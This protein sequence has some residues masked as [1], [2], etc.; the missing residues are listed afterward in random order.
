MC[1]FRWNGYATNFRVGGK[2]SGTNA[3]QLDEVTHLALIGVNESNADDSCDLR[4]WVTST[5]LPHEQD[6]QNQPKPAVSSNSIASTAAGVRE[7]DLDDDARCT[8]VCAVCGLLGE[9]K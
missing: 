6:L 1:S 5:T 2:W 8:Y 9:C 4:S 3:S 7:M